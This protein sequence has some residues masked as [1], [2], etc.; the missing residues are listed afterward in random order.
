MIEPFNKAIQE[1]TLKLNELDFVLLSDSDRAT[2]YENSTHILEISISDPRTF[3]LSKT[4]YRKD[5]E[6]PIKLDAGVLIQAFDV[7]MFE[8]LKDCALQNSISGASE[9]LNV[10]FEFLIKYRNVIFSFPMPSPFREQLI[11]LYESKLNKYKIPLPEVY[12]L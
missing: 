5:A 9:G 11:E 8:H 6:K 2:K 7:Q 12:E 1:N 10:F 4:I 3:S